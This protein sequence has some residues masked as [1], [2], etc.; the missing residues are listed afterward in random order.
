MLG[1]GAVPINCTAPKP[2]LTASA[3]AAAVA[4][5]RSPPAASR[6]DARQH[7]RHAGRTPNRYPLYLVE[8]SPGER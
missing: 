8:F 1:A 3:G 7:A 2:L 5:W 6:H 4:A